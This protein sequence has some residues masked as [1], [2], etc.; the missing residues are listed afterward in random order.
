VSLFRYSGNK[1]RMIRRYRDLAKL[2]V[3]PGTTRLVEPFL[4]S[5]AFTLS[6]LKKRAVK[7]GLGFDLDP[8][9]VGLWRWLQA[10][11]AEDALRD[12]AAW[13]D[14]QTEKVDVREAGLSEGA[15][16]Y[17]KVNVCG[18]YVGQWSSWSIYPEQHRLPLSDTLYWLEWARR[19]EVRGGGALAYEP[20]EGDAVFI[21]PPYYGT[22]GNY[23]GE[24]S[25]SPATAMAVVERCRAAG[26]PV[27]FAY[28]DGADQLYPDLPWEE[29]CVRLVPNLRKGGTVERR[30]YLARV[31]WPPGPPSVFDFF[32]PRC[33]R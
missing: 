29:V 18:A 9:V 24:K 25:F 22:S 27:L 26:V 17:L 14:K 15:Q 21:D 4:G 33:P 8:N 11:D 2:P 6:A 13:Y 20:R 32:A 28:G 31:G 16:L 12:L 19:V 10:P 5:G 23:Q 1:A 3:P 30:E 7:T